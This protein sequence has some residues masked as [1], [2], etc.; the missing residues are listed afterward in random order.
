MADIEVPVF[1]VGGGTVG[2]FLAMELGAHGVPFLLVDAKD[3]TSTHP[4]GST[5]NSRSMEHLR[6]LGAAA[7]L[8]KIG[9]PPDHPTDIAYVTRFNGFELGRIEMPSTNDK[10]GNPGPWGPTQLTPEPIHRCNQMYL[11]PVLRAHAE[12]PATSDLRFGWKMNSFEQFADHVEAEIEEIATGAT[13]SVRSDYMVACDGGNGMVRRELGFKYGGRSSSG[14]RF[15]DGRMLS[16][17]LRAPKVYDILNFPVAWHFLTINSDLRFDCISLDCKGEFVVLAH[18]D[19][20]TPPADIDARALFHKTIGADVDAEIISVQ[21]WWAGLALVLDN[22]QDRRVFLAGDS[23]HLF[24]PS[25]GFGFNTGMDDAANLAWKLAAAVQG[26]GG[27]KLLETYETERQPIGVRNTTESGKLAE[28]IA[29]L[30]IPPHIEEESPEGEAERAA[31]RVDVEKFREEFASLGIQLGARYDGSPIIVS[32]GTT[33]PPDD[34]KAYI[35]S[36]VP[37]GRAPHYWIGEKQSLFDT[38]GPGFTL[39]RIGKNAPDGSGLE[40]AAKTRGI[41]FTTVDIPE[42]AMLE[43]YQSPLALIRPDQHVAW[44]GDSAPDDPGAMLDIVTGH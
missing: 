21:E 43:L 30:Q 20:E 32:D 19:D 38:F 17:Y 42:P 6:R 8:R 9:V 3:T 13:R 34:A 33:P 22:Y 4:K 25:G 10:M 44:R 12:A 29:S 2:L 18:V 27:A 41:P 24:T 14:D 16:I 39:L 35:P 26:W 28:Q 36:A 40:D 11:E 7:E 37:G 5:V 1:V 15:Y 23:V 31:F